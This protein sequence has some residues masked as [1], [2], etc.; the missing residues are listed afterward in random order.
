MKKDTKD[1][2][3]KAGKKAATVAATNWQPILIGVAVLTGGYLLYKTF[4]GISNIDLGTDPNAGGGGTQNTNPNS[5]TPPTGATITPNQAKNKAG[6]LLTAFNDPF[7]T[8][9]EAVF[10]V[11]RGMNRYD[12]ALISNAFGTPR[13][14]GNGEAYTWPFPK[15]TLAQWIAEE[16]NTNELNHL[17]QI[18]PNVL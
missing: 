7:G 8:D 9:E 18:M 11:L 12:F 16:L 2:I 17:K 5:N 14:F 10:N 13:Y 15:L 4:K 3:V 1:K 6:L